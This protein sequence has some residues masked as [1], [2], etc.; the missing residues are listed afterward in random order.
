MYINI[1]II[2]L[3]NKHYLPPVILADSTPFLFSLSAHHKA[4]FI[5]LWFHSFYFISKWKQRLAGG[6]QA[7]LR[8][9]ST[10]WSSAMPNVT[11]LVADCKFEAVH[12]ELETNKWAM[13]MGFLRHLQ[14]S[15]AYYHSNNAPYSSLSTCHHCSIFTPLLSW[16]RM[17]G[18]SDAA[19]PQTHWITQKK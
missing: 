19:C 16:G 4:Q 12:M 17:V 9:E 8:E 15:P 3:R 18:P 7:P 5:N 13:A 6:R 10:A 11:M 14:S 1:R 2:Y